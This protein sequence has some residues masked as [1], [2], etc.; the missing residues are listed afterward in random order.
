MTDLDD[1]PRLSPLCQTLTRDGKT[2]Q[3]DIYD[4]GAGG[5]LLEV[6]DDYGN[7]TVWQSAFASDQDALDEALKTI[8]ESGI[9]SL[10]GLP[11]GT[12]PSSE[13]DQSL[14]EEDL[15]ELDGF[16][17]DEAIQD[18]SMDVATLEGFLTAIVIG[19]R[20]VRPS[21]WL[22]W[23]WDM[24]EGE[25]EPEFVNEVHAKH[26]MSLIMRCC[27]NVVEKFNNDPEAFDPIFWHGDQWGAAEW[28]EGFI[29]GFIFSEEAW[30]LLAVGQPKWFTPFLRLG[31]AEG[32][33]I[34]DRAG[35]AEKVMNEIGPSL[36]KIH[37]YWKQHQED[38]MVGKGVGHGNSAM[39]I[40]GAPKIGRNEPCP[41][42]SGKKFKKCCGAEG[43]PPTVH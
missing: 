18:T 30:S 14:T 28:C 15:D 3:V 16:F 24:D 5:W 41:C 34:T 23:V 20:F 37:A 29:L 31:T 4:D 1:G 6:I 33:V 17:A 27:N 32:V 19:P 21:E 22:P 12:Q 43:A 40:R 13:L 26:I 25:V 2:V 38:G 9:D 42:G 7:S 35:D 8:D 39:F 36:V 11:S 10:I